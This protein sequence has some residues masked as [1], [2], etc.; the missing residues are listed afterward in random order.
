M[1]KHAHRR[2]SKIPLADLVDL[3]LINHRMLK[4]ETSIEAK[5]AVF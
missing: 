5:Y 3:P 1:V 2:T 4:P